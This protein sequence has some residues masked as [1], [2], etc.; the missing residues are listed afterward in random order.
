VTALRTNPAHPAIATLQRIQQHNL[1]RLI[2]HISNVTSRKG[3]DAM[4]ISALLKS[5]TGA[6]TRVE[7]SAALN[8]AKQQDIIHFET[9]AVPRRSAFPVTVIRLQ[10]GH[11]L[12]QETLARR[13][14]CIQLTDT[15][16][17]Q[18]KIGVSETILAEALMAEQQID[19][20]LALFWIRLLISEDILY[21]KDMLLESQETIPIIYLN[22][23]DAIVD[24]LL[25]QTSRDTGEVK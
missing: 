14:Q 16:I 5:L 25:D 18:R 4:A 8:R 7:A 21:V 6:M 9:V 11:A 3:E 13:N 17:E 1:I 19:R 24:Q 22:Q 12:V 23:Q 15:I 2:L 20:D 10:H